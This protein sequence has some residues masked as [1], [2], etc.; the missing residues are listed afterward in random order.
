M[1]KVDDTKPVILCVDDEVSILKSLQRLFIQHDASLLLADSGEKALELMQ[2]HKVNVIISD[3]RMPGMTG[4][5]FLA[6]AAKAQPDAYRILMTGY[7]DLA[8]TISA[9]NIGRIH[10]YVQKP[11]DNQELIKTVDEGLA[12]YHLL[13]QNKILTAKVAAQNKQLKEMNLSLEEMVHQRTA[14]LKQ[15]V[16]KFK[17]LAAQREQEE[18]ATLEVLYNIISSY[19]ALSGD[20][21]K[22]ISRTCEHISKLMR[23]PK[24]QIDANKKAGLFCELGKIA[25]PPTIASSYFAKLDGTDRRHFFEHPQLA[26]EILSP[27]THLAE[28]ASIIANQLERFNGAGEP[29]QKVGTDIPLGA[30]ILAVARDVWLI[31]DGFQ[32]GKKVPLKFAVETIRLHQG[33]YYDPDVVQ[34]LLTLMQQND[35]TRTDKIQNGID[36]TKL[37]VGMKLTNNL[38]NNKHMLLLPKEHVITQ[39]SL[40]KLLAYQLKHKEALLVPVESLDLSDAVEE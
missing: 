24:E 9:I 5:E 18:A 32:D 6:Q 27:A 7:A 1:V 38:Y 33:S 11:W 30:R 26:E 17:A 31:T 35:L 13:R 39:S 2:R 14:Q 22:K 36:V 21:A 10:R 12:Y 28:V 16:A 23:L 4:A 3:M 8:S 19:P 25:L 34:A 20:L 37:K 29:E 15:T 40:D